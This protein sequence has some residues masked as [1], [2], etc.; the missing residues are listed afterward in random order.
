MI[1]SHNSIKIDFSLCGHGVDKTAQKGS[2]LVT[3]A[4]KLGTAN[5]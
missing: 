1:Q 3:Q 4:K 2:V 5:D